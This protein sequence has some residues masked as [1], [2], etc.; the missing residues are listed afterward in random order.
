MEKRGE[1]KRMVYFDPPA[2]AWNILY[3]A[4]PE[5][6]SILK[7]SR[8]PH[9]VTLQATKGVYGLGDAPRLW[10]ERFHELMMS[11]G[12]RQSKY[13][14]CFYFKKIFVG[15]AKKINSL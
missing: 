6:C 4:L 13:D 7:R 5:Q 1:I 3:E 14:E 12:F 8:G 9:D 2:D 11:Q 15:S 10:R